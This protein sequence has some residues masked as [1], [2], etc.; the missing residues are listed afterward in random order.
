MTVL[1]INPRYWGSVMASLFAGVNFPYLA[2][3]EGMG[4]P[5]PEPDFRPVRWWQYSAGVEGVVFESVGYLYV[6]FLFPFGAEHV[7]NGE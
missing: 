6:K 5:L 4:I 1:E 7:L 2:C 3:M